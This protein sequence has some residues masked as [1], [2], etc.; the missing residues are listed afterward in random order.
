MG[1]KLSCACGKKFVLQESFKGASVRCPRCGQLVAVEYATREDGAAEEAPKP[2]PSSAPLPKRSRERRRPEEPATETLPRS[3]RRPPRARSQNSVPYVL[4]VSAAV[5]F[6][7]FCFAVAWRTI[8]G[9]GN[10]APVIAQI[11]EPANPSPSVSTPTPS[12]VQTGAGRSERTGPA[13]SASP[14]FTTRPGGNL[15]DSDTHADAGEPA[16]RR[17]DAS[18]VRLIKR[19]SDDDEEDDKEAEQDNRAAAGVAQLADLIEDVERCVVRL[20]FECEQGNGN[21]SGFVVD[22]GGTIVTNYHVVE[23]AKKIT[24]LF[25]DKST[26]EI[27]GFKS[28]VPEKDLAVLQTAKPKRPLPF[29]RICKKLPRKGEKVV[30]FGSPLGLSFSASEGIVSGIRPAQELAEFGLKAEGTWIQMTTQISPGNSGGPLVTARGEVAGVNTLTV[31]GGQS[32]N[33]AISCTDARPVV[34]KARGEKVT[35]L[36]PDKLPPASSGISARSIGGDFEGA[37]DVHLAKSDMSPAEVS[38]YKKLAKTVWFGI[39]WVDVSDFNVQATRGLPSRTGVVVTE[40]A[41]HSPAYRAGLKVGDVIRAINGKNAS[42]SS[43]VEELIDDFAAGQ[44]VSIGMLRPEAPGRY[45]KKEVT[46]NVEGLLAESVLR[47]VASEGVP[48]EVRDFLKRHLMR[49]YATLADSVK[50]A[51]LQGKRRTRSTTSTAGLSVKDLR[52]MSPFDPLFLPSFGSDVPVHV[53]NIGNLARVQALAIVGRKMVV[54]RINRGLV[55]LLADTSNMVGGELMNLG[56]A[57]IVGT[58]VIEIPDSGGRGIKI[59]VARPLAVEKYLPE[60]ELPDEDDDE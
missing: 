22:A 11:G 8:S 1:Q 44:Q 37:E 31:T 9:F 33:F 14:V 57:Q 3:A 39:R 32:L 13:A 50:E 59:F 29:L 49:Y 41:Y 6:C 38:K 28:L 19:Q 26:L 2:A 54:A 47:H 17:K 48:V 40:V 55:A 20:D 21:G 5:A 58:V 60:V 45:A 52:R 12:A 23:G 10:N 53:G 15:V 34:E 25:N 4:K 30:A 46:V 42:Q 18:P 43:V 51:A 16:E 24:A 27:E 7:V 36:S 35:P 56:T